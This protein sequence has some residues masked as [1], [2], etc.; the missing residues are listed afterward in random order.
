MLRRAPEKTSKWISRKAL[1]WV[2][3]SIVLLLTLPVFAADK[4]KDEDTLRQAN[5]V[6]QG[7]LNSKDIHRTCC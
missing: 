6:L 4:Q 1:L 3:T 2:L 7:L 5:L